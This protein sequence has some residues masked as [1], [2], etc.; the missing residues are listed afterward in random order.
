[1]KLT[2]RWYHASRAIS[3]ATKSTY[4]PKLV[5]KG[6]TIRVKITGTRTGFTSASVVAKVMI[7]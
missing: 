6:H 5:D 2:Y 3:G 7:K 4:K 1:V